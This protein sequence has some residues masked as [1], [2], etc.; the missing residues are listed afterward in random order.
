MRNRFLA[1]YNSE[2]S[3][4]KKKVATF[5]ERH[6]KIA[7][8]LR[9]TENAVDDPHVDRLIQSF[10][11]SAARIRQKLDD[12]FPE[13]T[14]TLL[15]ALYPHYL[16]QIPS[17]TVVKLE[18][19]E[20]LNEISVIEPNCAIKTEMIR[21]DFCQ[22]RTTQ[23]VQ[24]TPLKIVGCSYEKPPFI[25]PNAPDLNARSCL[26]IA[27]ENKASTAP[28]K[29][30]LDQV[31]F[32]IKIPFASATMLYELILNHSL[33]VIIAEH[34]NDENAIRLPLKNIK[35]V[36]FSEDEAVLP[37]PK[38]G[39]PGF[40]LLTEFF[41]MQEKFLFF[42]IDN[43]QRHFSQIKE[44]KFQFYFYFEKA[45]DDLVKIIDDNSIDLHC[46]PAINLFEKNT[47]PVHM[48]RTRHEYDLIPDTRVNSTLEIHSVQ[49]VE[50][51]ENG[52]E[53]RYVHPFFGKKPTTNDSISSV[54]WQH[55][56]VPTDEGDAFTSTL[57][58]VDLSLN[59]Q[60]LDTTA[61]VS[62]STLCLNRGLPEKLPYGGGQPYMALINKDYQIKKVHCLLPPTPTTRFNQ[63]KNGY[64]RLISHL[65]LN[66]LAI[67]SGDPE[68]I[69]DILRLYD[70]QQSRET[71]ALIEAITD[72]QSEKRTARLSDGSIVNG[73][74]ITMTFEETAISTGQAYLF[75]TVL[76]HF[77][78]LYASINT[79]TR[80][81]IKLSNIKLPIARF[82]PR[83]ANE[84]L[85]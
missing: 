44:N 78:G 24:L 85:L 39:F 6:P 22:Y 67:T 14:N 28:S 18:P 75:G 60:T 38:R 50:I 68:L 80:L 27:L 58:L 43:L 71:N 72:I 36:G 84:V 33:G 59:A 47:E 2:L 20:Q 9:I 4:F 56:L 54:Y 31:C 7:G 42:K 34:P 32:Y 52:G 41:T 30:L 48:D 66:H 69:R 55:K 74:D 29:L 12:D 15:E 35:P 70:F 21:G 17:M 16:A 3:A 76:S 57:N 25:A 40:R 11:Y 23:A 1:W 65:S 73:V 53:S 82:A 81:T 45:I 46:T 5:A 61:V 64:W 26:T 8:R 13:L 19:V 10:S 79:F 49:R 62:V 37:F 63:E 51:S 83:T 77:F